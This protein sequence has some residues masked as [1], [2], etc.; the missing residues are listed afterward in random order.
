MGYGV[1][2]S[3]GLLL[4][5]YAPALSSSAINIVE[6]FTSS[7]NAI[8][9][10][11]ARNINW[12]VV[13]IIGIPGAIAA[14]IGALLLSHFSMEATK[15]WVSGFLLAM[16]LVILWQFRI[17]IVQRKPRSANHKWLAPV[18]ALAGFTDATSGGGWGVIT[19]ST[20]VVSRSLNP[21][22][23]VGTTIAARLIVSIS[24]STGFVIGL[25][26]TGIDWLVVICLL[27]GGVMATP[28]IALVI[29]YV[30]QRSIGLSMGV[31]L[32]TLNCFQLYQALIS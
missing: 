28:L 23:S 6:I 12:R 15:P 2:S 5:G 13:G 27:V 11:R 29:R 10:W 9:H 19:T 17:P 25:G 3:T 8:V 31:F 14:F 4:I 26:L 30:S 18:G 22:E 7:A 1:T 21:L 16:G 32:V 24:G 20:L